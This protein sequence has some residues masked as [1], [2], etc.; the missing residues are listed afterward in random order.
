M[1]SQASQ[2]AVDTEQYKLILFRASTGRD[3]R[4]HHSGIEM[5]KRIAGIRIG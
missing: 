1:H 3:L 4:M 5:N 2:S